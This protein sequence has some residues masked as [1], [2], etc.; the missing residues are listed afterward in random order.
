MWEKS[1]AKEQKNELYPQAKLSARKRAN[2]A[3]DEHLLSVQ[4]LLCLAVFA[5]VF[6]SRSINAPYL[7]ELKDQYQVMLSQGVEFSTENS[8]ARLASNF[9][10]D[11]RVSAQDILSQLEAPTASESLG[12]GGILPVTQT[13]S[14]PSGM[15]M[16]SYTLPETLHLPVSGY[17]SSLYGFR[18]HPVT[19]QDD[20]HAGLDI[21]AAQDTPVFAVLDG[22]VIKTAW[23]NGR[24]NYIVIRHANGVQTLY[25]HLSCVLLRA[26]EPIQKAQVIGTVGSTGV[27][28]GPHLHFELILNG[29]RV[30][31]APSFPQLFS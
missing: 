13:K 7:Q 9:V 6:F 15:S 24:G 28:T 29:M 19:G 16:D 20:F 1:T 18:K 10:S 12:Q 14:P 2:A 23:S 31:P 11:L 5:F 22:V 8:V 26:G 21:A 27:S 4:I 25:Q 30:D 17:V 3:G